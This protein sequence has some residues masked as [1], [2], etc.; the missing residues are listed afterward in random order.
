MFYITDRESFVG[1]HGAK[2]ESAM[3]SAQWLSSANCDKR[4][5]NR[6]DKCTVA[7]TR[8]MSELSFSKHCRRVVGFG[9][10]IV[11]VSRLECQSR[12]IPLFLVAWY[13][14]DTNTKLGYKAGYG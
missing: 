9:P 6:H 10:E 11:M 13:S 1:D 7:T 3:R 2:G 5:P 4:V 12:G 8:L 14:V